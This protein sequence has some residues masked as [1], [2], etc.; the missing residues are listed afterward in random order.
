MSG[1]DTL[2]HCLYGHLWLKRGMSGKDII[3]YH[4][5][6]YQ[7]MTGWSG[8]PINAAPRGRAALTLEKGYRLPALCA[9]VL[10]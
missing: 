4:R 9:R 5:M 2:C 10:T 6:Q 7:P 1:Q 8:A 3:A